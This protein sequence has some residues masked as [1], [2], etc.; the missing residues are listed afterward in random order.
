MPSH[1]L[2]WASCRGHEGKEGRREGAGEV[3][4]RRDR[5]GEEESFYI[6]FS[7]VFFV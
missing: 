1:D 4:G 3:G 2:F 7:C 5:E 6:P